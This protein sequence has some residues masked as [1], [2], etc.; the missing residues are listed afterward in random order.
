[1]ERATV[2]RHPEMGEARR[3]ISIS[4]EWTVK[5]FFGRLRLP[6]ND[7]PGFRIYRGRVR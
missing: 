3:R 5:R 6:Q 4:P 2:L 1:V 7:N